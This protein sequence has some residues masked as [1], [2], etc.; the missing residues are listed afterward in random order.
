MKTI[1]ATI[2]IALALCASAAAQTKAN[3]PVGFN[4][5]IPTVEGMAPSWKVVTYVEFQGY[6]VPNEVK[7]SNK[8]GKG[9]VTKSLF[10]CQKKDMSCE[11]VNVTSGFMLISLDT[12]PVQQWNE[13][14]IVIEDDHVNPH[15]P[16]PVV[17]ST[18]VDID[19]GLIRGSETPLTARW[20]LKACSPLTPEIATSSETLAVLGE[21]KSAPGAFFAFSD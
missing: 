10:R 3:L 14:R 21:S 17:S 5:V 12:V 6:W 11:V 4:F 18:V 8:D 19:S 15:T 20:N 2:L 1:L 9:V 13:H 7:D 16:C